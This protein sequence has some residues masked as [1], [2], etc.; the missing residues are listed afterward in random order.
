MPYIKP[1]IREEIGFK[2]DHLDPRA[3]GELNYIFT[4]VA[5][6]YL[7]NLGESYQ[8]FNDI[9]GALEGCKLELYRRKVA[10]YEDIKIVENGDV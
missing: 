10:P 2:V 7:E 1:E 5:H 6:N 3:A 4:K 9:I 8:A